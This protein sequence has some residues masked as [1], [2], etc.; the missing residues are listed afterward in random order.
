MAEM[1]RLLRELAA[2]REALLRS[3]EGLTADRMR[4]PGAEGPVWS[5]Q[6]VLGHVAAWERQTVESIRAY[7]AG[8]TPYRIAGFDSLAERD[9]W[10]QQAVEERRNWPVHEV[11]IELGVVRS[12][13][14]EQLADLTEVQLEDWVVYP[15]GKRG[16]LSR[17]LQIGADHEGEHAA[18]LAAWRAR[19]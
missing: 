19:L 6:D 4:E 17:L 16:R 13:L 5:A 1:S 3:V 15:W 2:Q 12:Q 14:L 9:R 11:L 8:T 10:N 18:S 7:G